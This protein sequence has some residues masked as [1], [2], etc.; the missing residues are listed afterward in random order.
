MDY[1]IKLEDVSYV[2]QDQ[3]AL[4]KI[5]IGI[6]EGEFIS[7][8]GPS[9][10][11]KSTLLSLLSG[12]N[13]PLQGEIFLNGQE[14][15]GVGLDRGVVF[16][17]YSLFPWMDAKKNVVFGLRQIY[18]DK[19]KSQL[20]AVADRY[21]EL[22]GLK[23]AAHKYPAQLSGGMQQRVAIARAFAMNPGILLMDEPFGAVD[24]K[25]RVLLQDLLLKLWDSGE[26]K[27]TVVFVTHDIDEAILLSD[28]IIVFSAGPGT[29]KKDI[30]VEFERPRDRSILMG[31]SE[32]REL[33]N[34]LVGLLYD[35]LN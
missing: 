17:H 4:S 25:N 27:K 3:L 16:Q 33:R 2:Y 14:I 1:K 13:P 21:L 28:R 5:N 23:E 32:Y 24:A 12:L 9:G 34:Q 11:G 7:I 8:I 26:E 22:V 31:K 15:E 30:E 18:K 20:E 29:V 10:C 19:S 35:D 6:R